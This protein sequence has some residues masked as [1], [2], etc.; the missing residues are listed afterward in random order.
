[1]KDRDRRRILWTRAFA[2]S[3]EALVLEQP[4]RDTSPEDL[5]V[6][7]EAV[8]QVRGD[9]CAVIWLDARLKE[10]TRAA[11]APLTVAAPETK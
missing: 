5:E 10:A 8:R 7:L 11:L 4:L 6:L 2:G 9:G 3:P 1:M